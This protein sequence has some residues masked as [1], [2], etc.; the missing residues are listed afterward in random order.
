ME[1][2]RHIAATLVILES[3]HRI[4]ALVTQLA[5][6]FPNHSCVIAKELTKLHE[7]LLSGKPTDLL[8]HLTSDRQ[9]QKG[10]FVVLID[11]TGDAVESDR[12][13]DDTALMRILLGQV[14]VKT[15]VTIATQLT[16]TK[17]NELYDLALQLQ[18]ETEPED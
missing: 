17:K 7:R 15:A 1:T 4:V 11:N 18:G 8:G 9:L 10:E 13:I 6:V 16:N 2:L 12:A 3:S 14:Q 5:E